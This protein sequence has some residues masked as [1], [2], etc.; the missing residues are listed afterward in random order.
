MRLILHIGTT[1]TGTTSIQSFLHRNRERL[2]DQGVSY[3]SHRNSVN[4]NLY[5][6]SLLGKADTPN[7]SIEFQTQGVHTLLVSSELICFKS[8]HRI[9]D[10]LVNTFPVTTVEVIC[11]A[12]FHVNWAESIA[13]QNI[14]LLAVRRPIFKGSS[15]YYEPR[16]GANPFERIYQS[17]TQPSIVKNVNFL[18]F[19]RPK[20]DLMDR[21]C[22]L[23]EIELDTL[24]NNPDPVNVSASVNFDLQMR[25][26]LASEGAL[27]K[28]DWKT[29]REMHN[30]IDITSGPF[31]TRW[32]PSE[33]KTVFSDSADDV[34]FVRNVFG[35]DFFTQDIAKAETMLSGEPT[36][37]NK[38]LRK[39]YKMPEWIEKIQSDFKEGKNRG[40]KPLDR[41][42][43]SLV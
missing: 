27:P 32:D 40:K 41:S 34:R 25:E 11:G 9:L 37:Q 39:R 3:A 23:A 10:A 5:F 2:L 20:E 35:S 6:K 24:T 17:W 7:E 13:A 36:D 33:L 12:R 4:Q 42:Q 21:F 29:Y 15:T 31:D 43:K 18:E 16:F 22:R 1:K 30:D 8:P 26:Q 28:V 38:D 19:Y 14:K